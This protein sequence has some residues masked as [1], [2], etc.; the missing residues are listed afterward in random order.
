MRL[1]EAWEQ[2]NLS[3]EIVAFL[4]SF[5]YIIDPPEIKL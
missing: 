5:A 1:D 3:K 4:H 2:Q